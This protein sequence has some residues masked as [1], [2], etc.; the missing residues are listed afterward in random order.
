MTNLQLFFIL[1][2]FSAT[3]DSA[4]KCEDVKTGK[5]ELTMENAGTTIITR[6]ETEQLE[7]NEFLGAR[8]NYKVLCKDNC[9]YQLFDGKVYKGD[10]YYGGNPTDTL[11]VRIVDVKKKSYKVITT[12]NFSD[13][14]LESELTIIK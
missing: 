5:F 4:P 10:S 14:K 3:Y 1:L 9:T 7:V 2:I 8:V 11:T 12:S 13:F 6:T